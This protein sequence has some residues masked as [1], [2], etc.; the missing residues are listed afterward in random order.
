MV[1]CIVIPARQRAAPPSPRQHKKAPHGTFAAPARRYRVAMRDLKR[2]GGVL[3]IAVSESHTPDCKVAT[4]PAAASRIQQGNACRRHARR[5]TRKSGFVERGVVRKVRSRGWQYAEDYEASAKCSTS[6]SRP[7]RCRCRYAALDAAT[8]ARRHHRLRDVALPF[9]ANAIIYACNVIASRVARTCYIVVLSA[10][11]NIAQRR[12][13]LSELRER[14][15]ARCRHI[16]TPPR[17][18]R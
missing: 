4:P 6:R 14:I 18:R 1:I 10:M 5:H 7:T 13:R 16:A 15:C 8:P 9:A 17:C 12:W 3:L 2:A 11:P